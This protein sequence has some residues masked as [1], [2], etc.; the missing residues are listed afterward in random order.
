VHR[1]YVDFNRPVDIA[2]ESTRIEPLYKRYHDALAT[3]VAISS[4]AEPKMGAPSNG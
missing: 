3:Y 2:I 1:K 4:I